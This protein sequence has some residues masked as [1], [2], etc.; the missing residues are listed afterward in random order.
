MITVLL[1][2][3]SGAAGLANLRL[4][5]LRAPK[6]QKGNCFERSYFAFDRVLCLNHRL[7]V[8]LQNITSEAGNVAF[9]LLELVDA[10]SDWFPPLKSAAGGAL[11]IAKLVKVSKLFV[12]YID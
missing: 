6:R 3:A 9:S 2:I 4:A 10:S 5:P 7:Q 11:H 12:I 8:K 1:I